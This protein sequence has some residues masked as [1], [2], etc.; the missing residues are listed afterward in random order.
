MSKG[1]FR[2]K[3]NS[4]VISELTFLGIFCAKKTT[5]ESLLYEPFVSPLLKENNRL[6]FSRLSKNLTC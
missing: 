3:K 2:A 4:L 1:I 5:D 6:K